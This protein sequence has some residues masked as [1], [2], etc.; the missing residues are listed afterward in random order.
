[1]SIWGSVGE[2]NGDFKREYFQDMPSKEGTVWLHYRGFSGEIL[3]GPL[4]LKST[5]HF[6]DIFPI[7]VLE[8]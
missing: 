3:K 2:S 8:T 6:V 5:E 1:M 4:C 7:E